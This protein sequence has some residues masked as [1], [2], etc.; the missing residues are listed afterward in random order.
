MLFAASDSLVEKREERRRFTERP[1]KTTVIDVALNIRWEN[2][3][4]SGY[5]RV[6]FSSKVFM[7]RQLLQIELC[8]SL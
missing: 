1:A 8:V 4:L 3:F 2:M 6:E 7:K 5:G